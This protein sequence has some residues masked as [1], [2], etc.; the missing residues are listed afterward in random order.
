MRGKG[1]L[2]LSLAF[3][4]LAFLLATSLQIQYGMSIA[5]LFQQPPAIAV[6]YEVRDVSGDVVRGRTQPRNLLGGVNLSPVEDRGETMIP[7]DGVLLLRPVLVAHSTEGPWSLRYSLA[8][9]SSSG[10]VL[11]SDSGELSGQEWVGELGVALIPLTAGDLA[12]L[13]EGRH[14]VR[15]VFKELVF[16]HSGGVH[17]LPGE[18]TVASFVVD[19]R[20]GGVWVV[21]ARLI[22]LRVEQP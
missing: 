4:S 12:S 3:A 20:G 6:E 19:V 5:S 14:V 2:L 13:G 22:P 16:R 11:T 9:E 1:V 10:V 17:V 8:V 15:L 18:A 7:G 21:G